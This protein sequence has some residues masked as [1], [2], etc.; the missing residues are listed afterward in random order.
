MKITPPSKEK[1]TKVKTNEHK[2]IEKWEYEKNL[3]INKQWTRNWPHQTPFRYL[4]FCRM[5]H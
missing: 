3:V 5:T 4:S 2:I 1:Q